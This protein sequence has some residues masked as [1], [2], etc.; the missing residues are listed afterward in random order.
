MSTTA[1]KNG[2]ADA[3]DDVRHIAIPQLQISQAIMR[4]EGISPLIM[5][6]W[7]EKAAKQ[8]EDKV[9]GKAK[10]QRGNVDPEQAWRDAAYV[11]PGKENLPDWQPGKYYFPAEAFKAAYLY[12]VGQLD[13]VKA[14]P[15]T[16]ATGWVY[17]DD[18]PVLEFESVDLRRDIGRNPTQ[19]IYRPQFN[20]WAVNLHIGFNSG[21][22]SLEQVVALFDLGGFSGGIGEWR[23]SSPKNKT[24]SYGRFRIAKVVS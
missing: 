23:P 1:L 12:G 20:N 14:F 4:V 13:D 6:K 10:A 22:I 16:K 8:L 18:N 19:P 7:S 11:I 3:N 17:V 21:S 2:K 9:T 15:K 24:G 5:H